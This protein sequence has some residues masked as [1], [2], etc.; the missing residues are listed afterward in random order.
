MR[1]FARWVFGRYRV[2]CLGKLQDVRQSICV[3]LDDSGDVSIERLRFAD[4]TDRPCSVG[5]VV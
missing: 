2:C 1:R 4:V 3:G 5:A